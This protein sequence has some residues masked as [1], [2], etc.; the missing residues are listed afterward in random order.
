MRSPSQPS[1]SGTSEVGD[2]ASPLTT[3]VGPTVD[4]VAAE[5]TERT[6]GAQ[7]LMRF[8][9]QVHAAGEVR[10]EQ[11]VPVVDVDRDGRW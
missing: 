8:E 1:T 2:H 9:R 5:Q 4:P 3:T 6:R 7:R 10:L 11:R